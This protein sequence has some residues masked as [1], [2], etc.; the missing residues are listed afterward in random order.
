M[1]SHSHS[2][3]RAISASRDLEGSTKTWS[4]PPVGIG[5]LRETLPPFLKQHVSNDKIYDLRAGQILAILIET[6]FQYSETRFQAI[7]PGQ[8]KPDQ[9]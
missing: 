5:Q 9:P 7:R 6:A 1:I 4:D 8:W 2:L 3:Q